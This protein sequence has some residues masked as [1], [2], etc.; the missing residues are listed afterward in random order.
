MQATVADLSI[1]D[2]VRT[3]PQIMSG[4][5][6]FKGTRVT[7]KTLFDHL[8]AGDSLDVFFEDFPAVTREQ[9]LAVIKAAE[10][11]LFSRL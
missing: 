5:P 8:E 3:D 6:C 9:A 10:N 11:S 7:V 1:D 4:A 2:V